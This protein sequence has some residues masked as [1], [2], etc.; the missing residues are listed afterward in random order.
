MRL[1]FYEPN[2][3]GHHFAY[4]ARMLP[5]FRELPVEIVVATT[6][7]ALESTEYAKTLAPLAGSLQI[8]PICSPPP[9]SPLRNARHRFAELVRA[10]GTIRPDHVMVCYADG[11]WDVACAHALLGRRPWPRELVVEGWIYR[12]RFGDAVDRRLRSRLRRRLFRQLLRQ[13]LFRRLHIDHELLYDFANPLAGGTPT[14]L[15]LTPNPIVLKP[16]V[17]KSDARRQLGLPPDGTWISLN[18]VIAPYKGADLLLDA[19]RHYLKHEDYPPARLL[20]AGPH[21]EGIRQL[22]RQSPYA[23]LVAQAR[24]VSLDRYVDENEMYASAAAADL[25]TAPYPRHQGRSSIILWAAAA[26][27]PS[28]GTDAS[29][30]GHVIRQQRLGATC[31]V[32]N[33]AVL[34]KAIAAMLESPWTEADAARVRSYAEFHRVENYQRIASEL[35]RQHFSKKQTGDFG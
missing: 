28:L 16:A 21:S 15:V 2:Y 33:P 32:T 8:T 7:Q 5:G 30:I 17:S 23:E 1:M 4:L 24:I 9:R 10:I 14:E 20:L 29:C 35:V 12:G 25:V 27:R 6:P 18:G 11:I 19:Y 31:A 34:A 22:L 3:T 13:G 26:G